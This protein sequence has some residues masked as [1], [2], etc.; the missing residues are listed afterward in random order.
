MYK[1]GVLKER[2]TQLSAAMTGDTTSGERE[3]LKIPSAVEGYRDPPTL[4]RCFSK[5]IYVLP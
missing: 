2:K 3:Y 5:R 1:A 4:H